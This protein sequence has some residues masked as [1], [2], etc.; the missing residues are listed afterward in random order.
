VRRGKRSFTT[1]Q[2]ATA[3]R[4]PDLVKRQFTAQ[5]PNELWLADITY[6]STWEGWLYVAFV[7]DVYSRQ[8]VGWQVAGH[9]RTD[10]VLDALEMVM[11]SF[12]QT[13]PC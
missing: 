2:D 3:T 10:L 12:S 8:I 1:I 11:A 4:P 9:V 5:R 7:L 6:C 13:R